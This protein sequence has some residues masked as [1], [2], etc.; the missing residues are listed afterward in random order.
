MSPVETRRIVVG[1]QMVEVWESPDVCFE[2]TPAALRSYLLRGA[3][4][5]LF[6]ALAIQGAS[7]QGH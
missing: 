5:T 3:W 1:G 6:N 2:L 7:S 4:V